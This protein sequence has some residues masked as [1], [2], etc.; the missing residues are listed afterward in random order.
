MRNL[1]LY[2]ATSLDGYIAR[3]DGSIDWLESADT[4]EEDYGY[5]EFFDS[6][7]TTLMGNRTFRQI[8]GFPVEFPYPGKR[9]IVFTRSEPVPS[10]YAEVTNRDPVSMIRELKGEDGGDIWLVGGSELNSLLL[11]ADLIDR[12]ILT[13][14]PRPLGSGIPLFRRRAPDLPWQLTDADAYDSGFL[15]LTYERRPFTPAGEG[16]PRS[17]EPQEDGDR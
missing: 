6:V 10:E 14:L 8:L 12:M 1:L 11:E 4:G 15:Q 5:Q 16:G 7:D 13:V 2:I 3:E 9:N 17:R